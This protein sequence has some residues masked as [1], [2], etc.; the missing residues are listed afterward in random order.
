MNLT[1]YKLPQLLSHCDFEWC[2]YNI[3]REMQLKS[4]FNIHFLIY[5]VAVTGGIH[6]LPFSVLMNQYL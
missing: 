3:E 1:F 5:P 2:E 6:T 4:D